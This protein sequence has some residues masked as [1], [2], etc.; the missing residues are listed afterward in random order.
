MVSLANALAVVVGVALAVAVVYAYSSAELA[1]PQ[2][3][4]VKALE[5]KA[6]AENVTQRVLQVG[7]EAVQA[8][9][10]PLILVLAVSLALA[11]A[12]YFIA[13]RSYRA[14]A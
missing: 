14:S 2:G 1:E 7:G 10:Q 9:L 12:I 8:Q 4:A 5:A 6:V 11:L 3:V 13:K